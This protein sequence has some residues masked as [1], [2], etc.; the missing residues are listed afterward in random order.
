MVES[1]GP[2]TDN[3]G[4]RTTSGQGEG[5]RRG[6]GQ[7]GNRITLLRDANGDGEP[8]L[9]TV[10]LDHLE[11]AVRRGAGRHELYVANTDAIV[12]Y[13]YSRGHADHRAG[14]RAG[15]PAGRA[16]RPSLDQE[17][18]RQPGR[19]EALCRRRLQQQHHRERHGRRAGPRGDLEVDRATGAADLC[20]GLRNP[21]GLTFEPRTGKFWAIVNERDEIG[22]D[23][24]PDYMTSVQDGGFYGWPYSY[25]GQHV[26]VACSRSV[27]TWSRRRSRPTTRLSSHVAPLGLCSSR[28][29][30]LPAHYRGGAFVGE[31]GS[32]DR[33]PLNGYK[34]VFVP[35]AAECPS[36]GR[37]MSSPDFIARRQGLPRPAGGSGGGPHG[38]LLIA[39]D[40]GNTVWR[41][42]MPGAATAGPETQ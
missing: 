25:W 39:D 41:A 13:P 24:V 14:R 3:S 40:A 23:L 27:P 6:G 8:D 20:S 33:S 21:T 36:G 34:V 4:L 5:P 32:W 17:P 18:D 10:L 28:A 16:D 31:H 35:F 37:R 38:A 26:D 12:G 2:G 22:P 7:G 11:L 19:H 1:N 42:S 15:R 30:A 29:N 9:H